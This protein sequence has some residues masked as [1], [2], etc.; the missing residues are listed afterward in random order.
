MILEVFS[1]LGDS[2]ILWFNKAKC[3]VLHLG[4]SSC[5][6]Q[7]RLGADLL[8]RSFWTWM[9]WLTTGWPWASSVCLWPRK[10]TRKNVGSRSREVILPL[11]CALVRP[12]LYS[13]VCSFGLHSS[14]HAWN[15]WRETSRGLQRWLGAWSISFMRKGWQTWDCSAWRRE[16]CK[17]NH[18]NIYKYL[19]DG[20][21]VDG[22]RLF[23]V[24][25]SDRTRG[26]GQRT[27][28]ECKKFHLNMKKFFTVRVT[29][30]WNRLSGEA[31]ESLS[32]E[33]FKIHLDVFLCNLL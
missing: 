8:E 32:M 9:F 6:Y 11:Y 28:L 13:T 7:Y 1:N 20:S 25:R 2:M 17:G 19:K 3:R 22:T 26:N 30:Y 27:K 33:I 18:I 31:V 10:W 5:T 24:V 21:Q 15:Y 23:S 4:R 14:K 12:H 29:E 16:D